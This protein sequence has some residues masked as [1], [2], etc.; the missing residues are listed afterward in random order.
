M[1][2]ANY[3]DFSFTKYIKGA[4]RDTKLPS[5][6][7]KELIDALPEDCGVYYMCDESGKYVYIGKS[8]NI[9]ERILQH[10]NEDGFKTI[11]MRRMV[12]HI[13]HIHTGSELMAY[14]LESAEIKNTC[15]KLTGHRKIS[16]NRMRSSK[17]PI[18]E[19]ALDM[20]LNTKIG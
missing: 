18:R 17:S 10:F 6:L 5:Q 19:D 3:N 13:D 12:H 7:T 15:L 9:R 11:K 8:I 16:Q 20:K 4:L 14:L 1:L 2:E